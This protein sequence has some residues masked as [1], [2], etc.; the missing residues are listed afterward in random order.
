MFTPLIM[1]DYI[2]QLEKLKDNKE[3]INLINIIRKYINNDLTLDLKNINLENSWVLNYTGDYFRYVE[4]NDEKAIEWYTKSANL[5]NSYAMNNL[6]IYYAHMNFQKSIEWYIKSSNLDNSDA[7]HNLGCYYDFIEKD[8]PKAIEWYI[9][10]SNLDNNNAMNNLGWYYD[11][12]EKDIP[13]A[14]EWYI[15]SS[16][17]G[18]TNAMNNLKYI[19]VKEEIYEYIYKLFKQQTNEEIKNI[20]LNKLSINYLYGKKEEEINYL[21]SIKNQGLDKT[22]INQILKHF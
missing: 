17:L 16:N 13:K 11:N 21:K 18:N 15:K 5:G 22:L 7:M 20:L 12:I 1:N 2:N 6:G 19:Y 10:S 9:K 8:Y 3:I 14:I 4:K